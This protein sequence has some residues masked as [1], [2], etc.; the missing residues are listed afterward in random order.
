VSTQ[1]AGISKYLPANT[2]QIIGAI[3]TL[4]IIAAVL[5]SAHKGA[6]W[7]TAKRHGGELARINERIKKGSY[8]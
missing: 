3:V 4:L 1:G 7:M 5:I 8:R 2:D 6:G